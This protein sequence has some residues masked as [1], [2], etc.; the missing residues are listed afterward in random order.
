MKTHA[1]S[2]QNEEEH[3]LYEIF[4]LAEQDIYK[5][6]VCGE[7]LR[8]DGSSPRAER[9]VRAFNRLVGFFRF[10]ARVLL[11]GI[12]GRKRA[13]EIEDEHVDAYEAK[14][15]RRPRGNPT[16]SKQ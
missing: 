14:N 15:G 10:V 8:A 9:Q 3:H 11:T 7:P 6:G 13:E 16:R 5:Y 4:D 1:N 2:H 12:P